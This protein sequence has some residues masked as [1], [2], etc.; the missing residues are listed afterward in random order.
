M[1][2]TKRNLELMFNPQVEVSGENVKVITG[3]FSGDTRYHCFG[4]LSPYCAARLVRELRKSL[5]TIRDAKTAELQRVV[6][7]AE[8]TL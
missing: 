8:G 3:R 1:K 2:S 6:E 4:Y 7:I 5:R